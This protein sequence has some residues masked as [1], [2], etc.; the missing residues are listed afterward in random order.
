[1]AL[2]WFYFTMTYAGY[3]KF[4]HSTAVRMV[5]GIATGGLIL[6]TAVPAIATEFIFPSVITTSE[7]LVTV[8]LGGVTPFRRLTQTIGYSLVLIG[9]TGLTYRFLTTG[10]TK[11]WRLAAVVAMTLAVVSLDLIFE[12]TGVF[13]SGVDYAALGSA[14]MSVLLIGILYRHDLFASAPVGRDHLFR[15]LEEPVFVVDSNQRIMDWNEAARDLS[16]SDTQ[17]GNKIDAVLPG[18]T[19]AA[20]FIASATDERSIVELDVA[21]TTHW[22][23]LSQSEIPPTSDF[24]GAVVV[25]RDITEQRQQKQ[26]LKRQNERLD[27]F[28]SVVSHDLR[29]PLNVASAR[30]ALLAEDCDS[31]HLPPIERAHT[32][33]GALINDVLTLARESD[34]VTDLEPIDLATLATQCWKN[35]ETAEATLVTDAESMIQADTSRLRQ[36][37]ENLFRNATE[38]G[39]ENVTITVGELED[40]FYVEDD[41]TG[42]SPAER[43]DVFEA[44]YSTSE[45]GTGFGLNIV[46]QVVEA[47]D[48]QIHVTESAEGGARFEIT[49][50]ELPQKKTH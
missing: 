4:V 43:T 44:G 15:T 14:A 10:Y 6:A 12:K 46:K 30:L 28:A 22:Y 24:Q 9:T 37:F 27:D 19:N 34:A 31:E 35:V 45:E 21:D 47:H 8:S 5:V 25:L 18:E 39:G 16:T 26:E 33:M 40:G 3:G 29:N 7:P 49:G 1:M 13:L 11:S 23:E 42:I 17:I 36:V 32:R 50:V 2:S 20:E 38:H 41:G 48:W